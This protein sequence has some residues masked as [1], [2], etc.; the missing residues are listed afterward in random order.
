VGVVVL[1][2]LSDADV[3]VIPVMVTA[4]PDSV[5]SF[6]AMTVEPLVTLILALVAGIGV[7]A[8]SIV[9]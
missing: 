8:N 2:V 9:T 3:V 5:A 4:L 6:V 1:T 7:G